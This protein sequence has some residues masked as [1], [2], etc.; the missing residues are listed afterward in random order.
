MIREHYTGEECRDSGEIIGFKNKIEGVFIRAGIGS[1]NLYV[2]FLCK[3]IHSVDPVLG[4]STKFRPCKAHLGRMD[5]G[6]YKHHT[7]S[8]PS[9][10]QI[11]MIN[12]SREKNFL[13]TGFNSLAV[14]VVDMDPCYPDGL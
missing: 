1:V 5:K 10:M 3:V 2:Q 13:F 7:F 9:H 14:G 8:P 12:V 6:G 11:L 4:F